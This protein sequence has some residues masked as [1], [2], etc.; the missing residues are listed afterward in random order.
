VIA[1]TVVGAVALA[2]V[3]LVGRLDRAPSSGL[4]AIL[5]L[6]PYLFGALLAWVFAVWCVLPDRRS[7]PAVLTVLLVGMGVVWGPSVSAWT[8]T[9]AAD[10]AVVRV[11]SWNLRRLWGWPEEGANAGQCAIDA[12]RSEAPDVL[13]L[14]EV[15]A[16]NV[17]MLEQA[18]GLTC[19]H[20]TY[21][22]GG[23]PKR[24]GLAACVRQDG[25]ATLKE[26]AV[27]R[28]VDDEDWRYVRSEVDV[29]GRPLNLL[30]VHLTPYHTPF[31]RNSKPRDDAAAAARTAKGQANQSAALL[32]RVA[33]FRDPTVVAGDFN[34]T[35]D[36]YLHA[37]LREHLTDTWEAGGVGIGATKMGLG[38]LPLR[39]DYIYASPSFGVADTR[40]TAPGCSD[41]R[42]IVTDLIVP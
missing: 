9:P 41:H 1:A 6:L 10:D 32:D 3:G 4:T 18:L 35:R 24:G 23:G 19:V 29:A 34:S 21:I 38:W 13:A 22:E 15:S 39:I 11:M 17:A 8:S 20:G 2:G 42:A 31:G 36:F 26:G 7:P 12:I 5:F 30:A 14:Q 25:A 28:F 37:A 16:E 33:R 40:V 27:L